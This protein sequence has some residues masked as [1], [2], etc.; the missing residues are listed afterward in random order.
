M[1]VVYASFWIRPR[2]VEAQLSSAMAMLYNGNESDPAK[3]FLKVLE[4]DPTNSVATAF[5]A[6]LDS[7]GGHNDRAAQR[8]EQALQRHP[9]DAYLEARGAPY[10]AVQGQL[11]EAMT[12]ASN[13]T[14]QAPDDFVAPEVWCALALQAR[15]YETA[16]RA[17]RIALRADP[18]PPAT[19]VNLGLA[20]LHF[21]RTNEAV[22]QFT[23]AA[24][25]FP[26]SPSA[27]FWLATALAGQPGKQAQARDQMEQ[28]VRL[29]PENAAWRAALERMRKN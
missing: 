18:F 14:S 10:V 28:A 22:E 20:L 26:V 16:E 21:G 1:A 29:D 13:A 5:L 11:A 3:G 19:H 2:T 23:V 4:T 7:R 25:G 24:A 27:H 6:E 8:V 15:Q 9:G 17:A 12:W